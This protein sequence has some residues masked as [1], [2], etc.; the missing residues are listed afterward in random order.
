MSG[1]WYYAEGNETRGP[2][3]L[4]ELISVLSGLSD[5]RKMLVWRDGFDDWKTSDSVREIAEQLFK[6]PPLKPRAP[7]TRPELPPPL[8]ITK[9]AHSLNETP[10]ESE[11]NGVTMRFLRLS[12]SFFGRINRWQYWIGLAIAYGMDAVAMAIWALAPDSKELSTILGLWMVVWLISMLSLITK[13]LHDMN[14]SSLWLLAV[15]VAYGLAL[16]LRQPMLDTAL[17]SALG[18]GII[19]LGCFRSRRPQMGTTGKT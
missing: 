11:S 8:N 3:A 4:E 17:S 15:L 5:A 9:T 16:T 1:L 14:I 12:F 6:P 2:V 18:L 13:R 19:S 7:P 10:G